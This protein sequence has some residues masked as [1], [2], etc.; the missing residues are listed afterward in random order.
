MYG[1]SDSWTRILEVDGYASSIHAHFQVR[2]RP[3]IPDCDVMS[4]Q[5]GSLGP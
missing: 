3:T 2:L 1:L 5:Y 4:Q